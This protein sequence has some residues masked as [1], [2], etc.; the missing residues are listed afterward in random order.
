MMVKGPIQTGLE[1]LNEQV[2]YNSFI[3]VK[4][5][6]NHLWRIGMLGHNRMP[7]KNCIIHSVLLQYFILAHLSQHKVWPKIGGESFR[8]LQN[9]STLGLKHPFVISIH[10]RG[11]IVGSNTIQIKAHC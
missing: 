10:F 9:C 8:F 11:V 3:V 1:A 2:P 7:I 6:K 5:H 4:S